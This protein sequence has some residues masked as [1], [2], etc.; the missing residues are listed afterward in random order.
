MVLSSCAF[1][2]ELCICPDRTHIEYWYAGNSSDNQLPH[3]ANNLR[4]YLFDA[5]GRLLDTNMLR[6]DSLTA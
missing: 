1:D 5:E 3:Y 4:Q 6:G 2:D